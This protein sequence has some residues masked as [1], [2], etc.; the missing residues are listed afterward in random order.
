[1][2]AQPVAPAEGLAAYA[3]A[4][5]HA[6]GA[7]EEDAAAWVDLMLHASLR[8]VDSHGVVT[9]LPVFCEQATK[10]IGVPG[11]APAVV[12][13]RGA[14][15]VVEGGRTGGA[16]T[17]RLAMDE[18][19]Q[20][21]R[22]HGAGVAVVRRVGY[23]GAL[24]W[25]IEPA[26]RAGLIALVACNAMAFVAPHGGREALHGTNPIA[27][28]IPHEPDPILAD[29]RTNAFHMRDYWTSLATGTPLPDDVLV[30]PDGAPI[31]DVAALDDAWDTA[32]SLPLAGAKGYG[33][34]LLVDVLT[35]ALAGTGIGREVRSWDD[36]EAG[37]AA[38]VLALDPS[39]FGP[40]AS[41]AGAVAR[42]AEQA[43]ATAP[44]AASV[45]VRLPGERAADERRRRLDEGVPVDEALWERM[46]KALAELR[47]EPPPRP[48]T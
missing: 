4:A 31:T 32:V 38:F 37:L 42:L 39:A 45:P 41:F 33:L 36:E 6:A 11:T 34:A 3:I 23:L 44:A 12:E 15:C 9:L 48:F 40:I 17:A 24:A 46:E 1:V 35:A 14:C 47:V 2:D 5:L 16:R 21:A 10:G 43:H 19:A 27:F 30:G 8:G 22:E 18:A 29:M 26:A 7:G 25:T 13:R 28:A 20:L